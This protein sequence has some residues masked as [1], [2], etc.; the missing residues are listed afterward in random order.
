MSFEIT[1]SWKCHGGRQ[2]VFEHDSTTCNTAMTGSVYLP[3][4]V[5]NPP[6]LYFLS[7]LTCTW[8]NVTTKGGFQ[9]I[10]AE[11]GVA[12]VAPDTSPR[13]D[14]VHDVEDRWDLG[15]GA[16]FYVDALRKPWSTHYQMYSYVVDELPALIDERFEVDTSRA[17]VMG[18][19]MGGHGALVVGL[20]NPEQYRSISALSPIVAPSQVQWGEDAF[21]A[22][23]GERDHWAQ[24]DATQLVA[25]NARADE[26]ILIDQGTADGFLDEQLR[27]HLFAEACESAGQPLQLNL[28]EGYDHSYYFIST[29]MADHVRFHAQALGAQGGVRRR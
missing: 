22:Y 12:L 18:H 9:G 11:L 5:D 21:S 13:G 17:S 20:R 7:G 29:F 14:D 6:V 3:P 15:K 23:L 24:Y 19:S 8:E 27:P 10:C 1:S 25:A 4:G 2:L 28:R 16:G 26:P